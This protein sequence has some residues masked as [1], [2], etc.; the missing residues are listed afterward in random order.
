MDEKILRAKKVLELREIAKAME[1]P[2][3][4]NLKKAEL[5]EKILDFVKEPDTASKDL[6]EASKEDDIP[7]KESK[8]TK[9]KIQKTENEGAGNAAHAHRSSRNRGRMDDLCSSQ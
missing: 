6:Q 2:G 9:D 4:G 8:A 7:A 3:C 5:I 1:I